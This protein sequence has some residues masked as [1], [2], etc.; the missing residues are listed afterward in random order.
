MKK[1]KEWFEGLA[2]KSPIRKWALEQTGWK[3]WFY[4]LIIGGIFFIII[5]ILLNK[6]GMTMLPWK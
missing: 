2:T 1:M 3:F 5:E 6:I 4:Q